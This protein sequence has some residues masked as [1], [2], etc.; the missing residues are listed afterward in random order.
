[1][2]ALRHGAGLWVCLVAMP[3]AAGCQG[4]GAHANR[5][6]VRD[7]VMIHMSKGAED[8]HAVAMALKMANLMA[9][10]RDVLVYCDLQGINAVL[11]DGPEI[12]FPTFDSARV[13]IASLLEKSVPVHACPGCLKALGK[14]PEDLMP[15]VKVA[16]KEAFFSFTR[17]RILTLD[18]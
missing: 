4:S 18:Y 5:A 9:A 12:S 15:G 7:G 1:M 16:D 14:A 10:D 17:G 6:G 13:Q 11:K 8:P 2:R 3:L